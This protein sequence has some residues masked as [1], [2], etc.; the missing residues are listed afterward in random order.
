M[1]S[2][3]AEC[4]L[5]SVYLAVSALAQYGTLVCIFHHHNLD[6]FSQYLIVDQEG[7]R[8]DVTLN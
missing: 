7:I 4:A 5:F 8:N 2:Y 3:T 1:L 6:N